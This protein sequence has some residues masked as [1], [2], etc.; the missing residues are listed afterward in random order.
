MIDTDLDKLSRKAGGRF[1]LCS[2]VIRRSRAM[3]TTQSAGEVQKLNSQ[4]IRQVLSEVESGQLSLKTP[5]G[6]GTESGREAP[7]A[8]SGQ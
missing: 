8:A 3:L 1:R 5:E 4:I 6:T 7:K 2:I